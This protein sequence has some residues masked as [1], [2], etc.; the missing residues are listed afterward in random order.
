MI[1]KLIFWGVPF[2]ALLLFFFV[3][4]AIISCE[5]S[6]GTFLPNFQCVNTSA[7]DYC[8][9]PDERIGYAPGMPLINKSW[10]LIE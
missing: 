7:L 4:G 9:L 5:V 1:L 2:L 3:G 8:L 10:G 6:E